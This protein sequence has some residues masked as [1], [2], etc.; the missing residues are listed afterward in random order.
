M[1]NRE[2][3]LPEDTLGLTHQVSITGPAKL[4]IIKNDSLSNDSIL[5]LELNTIANPEQATDIN[6]EDDEE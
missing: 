3:I 5:Q 4:K 1:L 6:L 2:L